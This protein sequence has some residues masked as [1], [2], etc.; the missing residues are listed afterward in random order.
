MS[1]YRVLV[2]S[3]QLFLQAAGGADREDPIPDPIL[4]PEREERLSLRNSRTPIDG[5]RHISEGGRQID[6]VILLVLSTISAR[7]LALKIEHPAPF[8]KSHEYPYSQR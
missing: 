2:E 7:I 1:T 4:G 6:E 5:H 8:H 3:D